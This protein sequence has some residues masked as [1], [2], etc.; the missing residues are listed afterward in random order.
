[1]GRRGKKIMMISRS[2]KTEPINTATEPEKR[3]DSNAGKLEYGKGEKQRKEK[4]EDFKDP[5]YEFEVR[6]NACLSQSMTQRQ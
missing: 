5:I 1:M 2:S 3:R 6:Y 4:K